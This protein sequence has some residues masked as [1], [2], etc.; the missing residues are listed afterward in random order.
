MD[1]AKLDDYLRRGKALFDGELIDGETIDDREGYKAGVIEDLARAREAVLAGDDGWRDLAEQ[2]ITIPHGSPIFFITK[3][4]F[5][6]ASASH[7]DDVLRALRMLWMEGDARPAERIRAFYDAMPPEYEEAW[8][9]R[10][11][12]VWTRLSLVALLLMALG[13]EYPPVMKFRFT[14]V[15]DSLE[16]PGPSADAD[17]EEVYEHVLDFLDRIRERARALGY[18]RPRDRLDAQSLVWTLDE[19]V[20]AH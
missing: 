18:E 4:D 3:I 5:L 6:S 2:G 16:H 7:P 15:W 11:G 20:E 19:F 1:Q 10:K 8:T 13:P 14:R 9:R 17:E 12:K